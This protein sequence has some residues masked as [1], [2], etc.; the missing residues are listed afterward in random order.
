MEPD[1]PLSSEEKRRLLKEQYK[2]ELLEHRQKMKQLANARRMQKVERTLNELEAGPVSNADD[3]L[4]QIQHQIAQA[5]ARLDLALEKP[6]QATDL[7][8]DLTRTLGDA[9]LAPPRPIDDVVQAPT[10]TKTLGDQVA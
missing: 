2:R 8:P 9:E 3:V 10:P 7:P 4:D 5:E 1:R 6:T